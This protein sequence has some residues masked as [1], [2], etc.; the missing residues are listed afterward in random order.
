[1]TRKYVRVAVIEPRYVETE[2]RSHNRP[3]IQAQLARG[4][5]VADPLQPGDVADAIAY[6]VTRPRHISINEVLLRPTQQE[7]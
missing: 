3:G 1:V 6:V 2:L 5:P 7:R 4:T